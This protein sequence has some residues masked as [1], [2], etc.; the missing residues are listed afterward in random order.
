MRDDEGCGCVYRAKAS[1]GLNVGVSMEKSDDAGFLSR[2][3]P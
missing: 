3:S 1:K 2:A